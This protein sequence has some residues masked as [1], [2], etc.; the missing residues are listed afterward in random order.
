MN[1]KILHIN[2]NKT[3]QQIAQKNYIYQNEEVYNNIFNGCC[4]CNDTHY[5][6]LNNRLNEYFLYKP[7]QIEMNKCDLIR[8]KYNNCM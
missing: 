4:I 5:S 1:N 7:P 8:I 6:Q 2:S 3:A